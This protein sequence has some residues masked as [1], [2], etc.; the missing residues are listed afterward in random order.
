M[1]T[2]K[3]YNCKDMKDLYFLLRQIFSPQ[4]SSVILL[5]SLDKPSYF[6]YNLDIMKPL[7]EHFADLFQN[8]SELVIPNLPQ[9]DIKDEIMD[10]H[11]I[12]EIQKKKKN[13]YRNQNWK[14]EQVLTEFQL[15][16][17]LHNVSSFL[18][19]YII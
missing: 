5:K 1:I 12:A 9:K 3:T 14:R 10:Y 19:R 15:K 8:P 18:Q 17:F 16:S 6:K 2:P 4:T 13:R 11:I 7:I